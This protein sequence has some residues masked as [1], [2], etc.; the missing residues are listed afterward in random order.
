M[1]LRIV[2]GCGSVVCLV[3]AVAWASFDPLAVLPTGV[4]LAAADG[5]A[6]WCL[7]LEVGS[8]EAWEVTCRDE[9]EEI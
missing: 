5:L 4:L 3:A 1:R 8:E 6:A 7:L 9:E 2:L